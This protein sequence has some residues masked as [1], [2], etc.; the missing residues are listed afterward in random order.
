MSPSLNR[1]WPLWRWVWRGHCVWTE[2]EL[3]PASKSH[4]GVKTDLGHKFQPLLLHGAPW[5]MRSPGQYKP[6]SPPLLPLSMQ[7]SERRSEA[8][9]LTYSVNSTQLSERSPPLF[10]LN[11]NGGDVQL[12]AHLTKKTSSQSKLYQPSSR[13]D[14]SR[15]LKPSKTQRRKSLPKNCTRAS[16]HSRTT[17]GAATQQDTGLQTAHQP[18]SPFHGRL[19]QLGLIIILG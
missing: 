3:C 9:Q 1:W 13:P 6:S 8:V 14:W 2:A 17:T 19:T 7:S 10:L 18:F 4:R 15:L 16:S 11:F 5:P 12:A